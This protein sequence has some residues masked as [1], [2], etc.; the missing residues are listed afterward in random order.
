MNRAVEISVGSLSP[1]IN[2][3]TLAQQEFALPPL[4]EQRRIAR[5]LRTIGDAEEAYHQ[6][7]ARSTSPFESLVDSAFTG[8]IRGPNKGQLR[9]TEIGY[10]PRH[11]DLC[12][13]EA[14]TVKIVDG[15][16]KRPNYVNTGVPFL[17]V[18][19]LTSGPGIDFSSTRFV[20]KDDH[21]EFV[22]RANPERGDV[23]VTKDGTLGIARVVETDRV[24][25]I[26]ASLALLKPQTDKIN[27]WFLK[28]YFDS[29]VFRRRIASKT[30]G[31]ALKHIHLVD[32]RSTLLP[33]PALDEQK[34]IVEAIQSI[35]DTM[36]AIRRAFKR[37]RSLK[38]A[39]W[40]QT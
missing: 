17:T 8:A 34:E 7:T 40:R 19:N 6:L 21:I 32:F 16:H 9:L 3:R 29:S 13:L 37:T 25:S 38:I 28:Y 4:E 30:S 18:E 22:K 11:W 23:L 14:V 20:S 26:F 2:W 1:T 15:V 5:F 10:I 39:A 27:P 31:S 24:F 35:E 36:A 12:R 33:F